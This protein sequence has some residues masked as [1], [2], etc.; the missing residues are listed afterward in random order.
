MRRTLVFAALFILMGCRVQAEDWG[1]VEEVER[2][3]SE[4]WALEA[5]KE[6]FA[7]FDSKKSDFSCGK[8]DKY[9]RANDPWAVLYVV[10][11]AA[12]FGD[13]SCAQQIAALDRTLDRKPLTRIAVI[14]YRA[15]MG[16]EA[17]LSALLRMF[18]EEAILSETGPSVDDIIVSLFGFFPDWDHTGR[19]LLRHAKYA[20][21]FAAEMN[22]NA[23]V[24]KKHLYG[25][26][27]GYAVECAKAAAMEGI[28]SKE[29]YLCN[30]PMPSR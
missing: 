4:D 11:D 24:W 19:R 17:A 21:G 25:G 18:D 29:S 9:V 15:K 20:D 13:T 1:S 7:R 12:L 6:S 2:L 23:L 8:L 3:P 28:A 27:P 14:F 26:T 16:N 30:P 10:R 22:V 5:T